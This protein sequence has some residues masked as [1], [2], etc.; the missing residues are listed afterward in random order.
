V[1]TILIITGT[2]RP[3]RD[4]GQSVKKWPLRESQFL[5]LLFLK[6]QGGVYDSARCEIKVCAHAVLKCT[7]YPIRSVGLRMHRTM[8]VHGARLGFAR[9]PYSNA[10]T[11]Q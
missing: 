3:E 2:P 7:D 4:S 10:R 6:L 11:T 1:I 5:K 9:T 8:I